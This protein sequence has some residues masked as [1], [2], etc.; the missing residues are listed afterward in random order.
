MQFSDVKSV[1]VNNNFPLNLAG[2]FTKPGCSWQLDF[3]K[4]S[5]PDL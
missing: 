5:N 2:F 4:R 3:K 1:P